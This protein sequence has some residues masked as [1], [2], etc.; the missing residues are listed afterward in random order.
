MRLTIIT[1]FIFSL[2][3]CNNREKKDVEE[4]TQSYNPYEHISLV[5]TSENANMYYEAGKKAFYQDDIDSS[6]IYFNQALKFEDNPIIYNEM[7]IVTQS[8]KDYK[9]ANE[10]FQIAVEKDSTYW[11]AQ[12]NL[13][14]NKILLDDD[15]E[16]RAVLY[17]IIDESNSSYWIS[18]ANLYLAA[19]YSKDKNS[20]DKAHE[21][22]TKTKEV[23]QDPRIEK[24]ITR[25]KR[26]IELMCYKSKIRELNINR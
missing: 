11:P 8:L 18:F 10:Y 7:G 15:D 6:Y 9:K 12:I 24:K 25:L 19:S 3:S 1:F 20:C 4:K 21:C 14:S 16:A 13:A 22:L 2:T 17:K 23:S 26:K 5:I